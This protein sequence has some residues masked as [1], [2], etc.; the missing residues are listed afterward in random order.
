MTLTERNNLIINYIPFA[1]KITKSFYNKFK[2]YVEYD[3]LQSIAYLALT[4]AANNFD[5]KYNFA[6]YAAIII[7]GRIIDFIR[8]NSKIKS[9]TII[10]EPL[11]NYNISFSEILDCLDN[12]EKHVV[13]SYFI[14]NNNLKEIAEELS[15][16]EARISQILKV[17][18]N[19][20]KENFKNE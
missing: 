20:I 4:V 2:N 9:Q 1:K 8:K 10:F 6:N 19:K 17:S 16:T 18:K 12:K 15:L 11:K 3:E 13:Q 7:Q 5:I 14:E